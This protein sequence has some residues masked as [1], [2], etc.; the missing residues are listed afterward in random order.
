MFGYIR[1]D[2]PYLYKK[3]ETLYNACYCGLCFAIKEL[4]GQ[5]SRLSLTYDVAFLSVL[6]HNFSDTDVN[7]QTKTCV[8]HPFRKR[9]VAATDEV[10]LRS[11]ALNVILAYYKIL[12]DIDDEKKKGKNVLKKSIISGGY[13][14]AKKAYP[15][16]D[17]I[18]ARCYKNLAV[19][20]KALC[21]SPD[22]VADDFALAAKDCAKYILGDKYSEEAGDTFY[23][24]GKWIYLIDALDDYDKDKKCGNYNV[25]RCLYGECETGEQLIKNH[26]EEVFQLLN[27]V[28]YHLKQNLSELKFY[29]NKDLIE[30][31]LVRGIPKVTDS[32]V[33]KYLFANCDKCAKGAK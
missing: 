20:E 2:E 29:F 25:F 15:E 8:A 21:D 18:V 12:D 4:C 26:G 5:K 17:G 10:F 31:V 24:L 19:K 9:K 11:A 13:K 33:K 27:S 14:K 32:I 22:I 7:I 1:T 30:N 3:D 6:L 16:I 28:F 23:F